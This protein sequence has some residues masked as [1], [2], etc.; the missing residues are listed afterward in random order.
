M[1]NSRYFS[2]ILTVVREGSI[3]AA[4]KKLY[5]SQPAVS[6][7]I[8]TVENELG[9]P[10][11]YR[12]GNRLALTY[13]GQLYIEA[14][15]Q[16]QMIECNLRAKIAESKDLAYGDF[17]LGISTQRGLQLLPEIIPL[18]IKKYPHVRI[19]LKEEGSE[20]LEQMIT[21]GDCD[22]AFITTNSKRNSL[23]YVPI[24]NEHV[25]L[26]AAKTTALAQKHPD[27]E[28]LDIRE[29]EDE[30]FIS[31][32]V[33]HSVRAIQDHLFNINDMHPRI[34]LETHNMEAAKRITAR[35][36]AVFLLPS[37]YVSDEMPFRD[38]LSVYNIINCNYER[39]FYFCYRQGMYLTG[40]Q[41]DLVQ[42]VC[43]A[44]NVPCRLSDSSVAPDPD[45]SGKNEVVEVF[46]NGRTG[47]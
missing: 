34:L 14:V 21:E 45:E 25:V 35:S 11:F 47:R 38:Q 13:A 43:D 17:R 29:A 19:R 39:H 16:I 22:I 1:I 40:Y 33:G 24:E 42:I 28:T 18:F 27:G 9:A 44:L 2:T 8:K 41:R 26:L 32:T 20:R 37:V 3:T 10:L 6:Q 7:T 12:E 4:S 15:E 5:I 36:E 46:P 31:M 23:Q 30:D